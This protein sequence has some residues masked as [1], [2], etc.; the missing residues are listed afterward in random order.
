[1]SA[2][3]IARPEGIGLDPAALRRADEL[4]PRWRTEDRVP[5]VGWTVGRQRPAK[6]APA[7]RKDALFL[8]ASITKPVTATAI[9]MLRAPVERGVVGANLKQGLTHRGTEDTEK[10]RNRLNTL[11]PWFSLCSRCLCG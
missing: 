6:D 11:F 5:A 10:I 1:M 8:I 4:V 9:M 3:P 7:I 2:I